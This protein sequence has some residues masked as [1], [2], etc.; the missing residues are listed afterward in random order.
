MNLT[1]EECEKNQALIVSLLLSTERKGIDNV[2][3]YLDDNGFFVVPSSM[4]RHHNWRGGLAQH[5]LGVYQRA[6]QTAENITKDN[7]IIAALLHDICKAAKLYYDESWNI[8]HHHTHI[9]GHGFRSVKILELCGLEF[10]D[11][12]RMAIRWHM[13]GHHARL[14]ELDEVKKARKSALWRV[15]HEADKWDASGKNLNKYSF[16]AVTKLV[17]AKV[18]PARVNE[19]DAS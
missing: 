13:V 12:E 7:I 4:Y 2:I 15:I 9:H 10:T 16:S 3:R 17:S 19:K 1:I 8:H 11:D 14:E 6:I 18:Q 5:S